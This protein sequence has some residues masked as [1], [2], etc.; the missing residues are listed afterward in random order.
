M[1]TIRIQ[2]PLKKEVDINNEA[3]EESVNP[4]ISVSDKYFLYS[5]QILK[6]I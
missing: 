4:D 3:L 5:H 1:N 6:L 2:P